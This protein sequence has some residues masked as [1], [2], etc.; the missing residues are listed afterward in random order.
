MFNTFFVLFYF[1][2]FIFL[3]FLI[4]NLDLIFH[5]VNLTYHFLIMYSMANTGICIFY[6]IRDN[7][8]SLY[9]FMQ[10]YCCLLIKSQSFNIHIFAFY[11]YFKSSVSRFAI[12][13]SEYYFIIV[14]IFYIVKVLHIYISGFT[15]L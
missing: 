3:F 9:I 8:A 6:A 1:I 13:T 2:F 4:N 10:Y 12:H 14:F 11:D 5:C 15:I 7:F